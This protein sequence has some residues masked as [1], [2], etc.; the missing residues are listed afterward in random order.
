MR[1]HEITDDVDYNK[2]YRGFNRAEMG[3]R[4]AGDDGRG[5]YIRTFGANKD[6]DPIAYKKGSS[7]YGP[8]QLNKTTAKDYTTRHKDLFKGQEEY[9]KKFDQQGANFNKFG[10]EPNRAGYDKK[11]DYG[12][13]GDLSDTKYHDQYKTFNKS[14]MKGMMRD[15]KKKNPNASV[16]DLVKRWRGAGKDQDPEY[17][18]RF[19]QGYNK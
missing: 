16:D 5:H 12:G 13:A 11:W 10:R 15:L 2:V 3:S 9:A 17:F 19:Y 1:I 6:K 18:D 14:V 8:T 4:P 7:A